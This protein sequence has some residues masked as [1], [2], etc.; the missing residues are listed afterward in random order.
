MA[1]SLRITFP[2]AFYHITARANDRTDRYVW[3]MFMQDVPNTFIF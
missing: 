3:G 1:L 2:G